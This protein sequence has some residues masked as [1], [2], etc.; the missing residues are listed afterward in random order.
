MRQ[1]LLLL[2]LVLSL[3][4]LRGQQT[5][6]TDGAISYPAAMLATPNP[7][8]AYCFSVHFEVD[9]SIVQAL[10]LI[11]AQ[12]FVIEE[13]EKSKALFAADGI[14]MSYTV[15][16]WNEDPGYYSGN[17]STAT[18]YLSNFAFNHLPTDANLSHLLVWGSSGGVAYLDQLCN[19]IFGTAVSNLIPIQTPLPAYSWNAMV[20][21]HELGHNLGSSHTHACVWNGDNSAIDG[22]AGATEG[23]CALP[24][25]PT[26][27]GTF[28]SYCHLNGG[29]NFSLGF[30]PQPLAV[31]KNSI[32]A[33]GCT[34]CDNEPPPPAGCEQNE[35]MVTITPDVYTSDPTWSIIDEQGNTVAAGGP[36]AR[37]DAFIEQVDTL[38][39]PDGCYFFEIL[40]FDGLASSECGPGSYV[41]SNQD[42]VMTTG[43]DFVG[44][45]AYTFCFNTDTDCDEPG[46]AGLGP[47][48]NQDAEGWIAIDGDELHMVGN[49]WKAKEYLIEVTPNTVIEVDHL[50]IKAGEIQ[51]IA[52]V[53][54][55]QG[56]QP[57][58]SFRLTG[59][60]NWWGIGLLDTDED[61]AGQWVH[62]TIPVGQV[63]Q[64]EGILGEH[65]YL[66]YINDHDI[67]TRDGESR[68]KNLEICEQYTNESETRQLLRYEVGEGPDPGIEQPAK[69]NYLSPNPTTGIAFFN[70]K[71][72]TH[73]YKV[74]NA[75]GREILSGQSD[76]IDLSDQ[77]AGVYLVC[78]NGETRRLIKF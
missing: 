22:C 59:T 46:Y 65:L 68:F 56:L 28:M 13:I 42:G 1:L 2:L 31:I 25:I 58:R 73:K 72:Q 10:G 40:D 5:C 30:G 54:T 75:N 27:G 77:P 43:A 18:S 78:Y 37:E 55:D 57:N 34:E 3:A 4:T 6:H 12:A 61:V 70:S 44:S 29:I 23:G 67:G 76:R 63:F 51:G 20:I 16:Y 62:Y 74:V 53:Q 60:Q 50:S 24:P 47:Y 38:C 41:I 66:V 45:A 9:Y 32:A 49:T 15:T 26:Q 39:L 17:G 64:Q 7:L 33:A 19:N 8:M 71:G 35:V 36:Y 69:N 11:P 52:I 14:T 48:A 21:T